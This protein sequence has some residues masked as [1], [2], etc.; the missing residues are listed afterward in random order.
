MGHMLFNLYCTFDKIYFCLLSDL[1]YEI[2]VLFVFLFLC[3]GYLSQ[4]L[5]KYYN[6][7]LVY[8]GYHKI[9][10]KIYILWYISVLIAAM[11]Y[12]QKTYYVQRTKKL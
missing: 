11:F 2:I 3:V 4:Y 1:L 9:I 10:E 6:I 8:S 7:Y 5:S 12:L